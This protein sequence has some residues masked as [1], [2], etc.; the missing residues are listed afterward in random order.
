M[1]IFLQLDFLNKNKIIIIFVRKFLA[2]NFFQKSIARS[3]SHLACVQQHGFSWSHG[4]GVRAM[5]T[6]I[7]SRNVLQMNCYLCW[8]KKK[9]CAHIKTDFFVK[10]ELQRIAI[11]DEHHDYFNKCNT[12]I[13]Y[14]HDIIIRIASVPNAIPMEIMNRS[15]NVTALV[16]K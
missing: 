16:V 5:H 6:V 12:C 13:Y 15:V 7:C 9:T 8:K 3:N 10:H 11:P 4:C 1:L 14:H 2:K